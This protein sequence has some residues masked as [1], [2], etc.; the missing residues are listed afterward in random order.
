M[1]DASDDKWGKITPTGRGKRGLA[2]GAEGGKGKTK[3]EAQRLS[4]SDIR[5]TRQTL[6]EMSPTQM[7]GMLGVAKSSL[8]PKQRAFA[9]NVAMGESKAE[10]YR[11]AYKRDASKHTLSSK[12]Y[13]LAVDDRIKAEI[14]AYKLASEAAKHRTPAQLRDLV[15]QTLVSQVIN[16]ETPPAIRTQAAKILGQVTEVA[17]FTERKESVIHHSSDALRSKILG[18]LQ[19]LMS[20]GKVV[21]GE[22]IEQD[23]ASLLGELALSRTPDITP[24]TTDDDGPNPIEQDTDTPN[25]K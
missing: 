11:K 7:V 12:P 20:G 3:G 25:D 2:G 18:E 9:Y 22:R 14:D 15:I 4:R 19:Q 23:A 5:K 8:T 13:H 21:E 6:S 17:A 16:P 10:A 24:D 1:S